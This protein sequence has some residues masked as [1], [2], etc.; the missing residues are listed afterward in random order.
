MFQLS[1]LYCSWVVA[2][3]LVQNSEPE[4]VVSTPFIFPCNDELRSTL[5]ILGLD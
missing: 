2:K 4:Q 3:G 5:R 1:G